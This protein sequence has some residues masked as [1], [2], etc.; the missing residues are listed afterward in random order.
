MN[1]IK[2]QKYIDTMMFEVGAT[3]YIRV[4]D[5]E[6]KEALIVCISRSTEK[7]EFL[8]I[9]DISGTWSKINDYVTIEYTYTEEFDNVIIK[10]AFFNDVY[11]PLMMQHKITINLE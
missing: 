10:K 9:F 2:E 6:M 1:L 3:Y 4:Y 11:N 7:A 8:R 5:T